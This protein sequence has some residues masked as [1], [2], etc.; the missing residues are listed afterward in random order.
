MDEE[1]HTAS[2]K[3]AGLEKS[4]AAVYD[5]ALPS[6]LFAALAE[7]VPKLTKGM[8]EKR[9]Q[10][11]SSW[12]PLHDKTGTR[13]HDPRSAIESCVQHLHGLVFG[14]RKTPIVGGEWW[15]R[16]EEAEGNQGLGFHFDKDESYM[17]R[18]KVIRFPEVSTVTYLSSFGAPTLVLNQ[19]IGDG[20]NAMQPQL[21]NAALLAHP[22]QNRQAAMTSG[23]LMSHAAVG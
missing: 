14:D 4:F 20:A 19:T 5:A 7:S 13:R 16:V 6:E 1:D 11:H 3:A 10:E 15:L 2:W 22:Q 17:T 18:R 21:A 9:L 12:M 8:E 23:E